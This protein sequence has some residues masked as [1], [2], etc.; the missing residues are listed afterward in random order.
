MMFELDEIN[1][2]RLQS[3]TKFVKVHSI[4]VYEML[5]Q[6]KQGFEEM[7]EVQ[8]E[9]KYKMIAEKVNPVATPLPEGSSEVIEEA[10]EQPMLRNPKNIGHKF[11]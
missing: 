7:I 8:V 6:L 5:L 9:T 2:N 1:Q 10:S 3:E 4:E 11:T